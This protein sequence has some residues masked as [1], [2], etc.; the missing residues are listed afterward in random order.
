MG[1]GLVSRDDGNGLAQ[2]MSAQIVCAN[3]DDG[4]AHDDKMASTGML[5]QHFETRGGSWLRKREWSWVR[6]GE[7]WVWSGCIPR[8]NCRPC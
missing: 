1:V 8:A 5:G 7:H 6:K 3:E 4:D 2:S